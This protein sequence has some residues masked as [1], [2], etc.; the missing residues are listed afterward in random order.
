[1]MTPQSSNPPGWLLKPTYLHSLLILL[2]SLKIRCKKR[3]WKKTP[4]LVTVPHKHRH[5]HNAK[6]KSAASL[7]KQ[8][9]SAQAIVPSPQPPSQHTQREN[10]NHKSPLMNPVPQQAPMDK[11][12]QEQQQQT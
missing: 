12:Q 6:D 2:C 7:S 11:T 4:S 8:V 5:K 10:M 1:L 3:K 9:Q